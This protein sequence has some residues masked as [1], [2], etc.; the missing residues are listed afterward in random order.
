MSGKNMYHKQDYTVF[1][2]YDAKYNKLEKYGS[3]LFLIKIVIDSF[4][5]QMIQLL[6][7]QISSAPTNKN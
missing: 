3:T 4:S 2:H 1:Y 5:L 6:S 7:S